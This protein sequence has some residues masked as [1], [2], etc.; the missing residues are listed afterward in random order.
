MHHHVHPFR[1]DRAHATVATVD[2]TDD[3]AVRRWAASGLMHLT[4]PVTSSGWGPPAGL[5]PLL[6][7]FAA[8]IAAASERL[9]ARVEIDPLAVLADRAAFGGT[10]RHGR[11]SC[12]GG[13]RLLRAADGWIALTLARDDDLDLLPAWSEGALAADLVGGEHPWS[14]VADWCAGQSAVRLVERGMLLGLAVARLG[15]HTAPQGVVVERLGDAEPRPLAETTVVDLS[16]LWSG[17][18]CGMLLRT[19]GCRVVKVESPRRPDG[20]R[21]G[22]RQFFDHLHAGSASVALD[23][24]TPSGRD[25]LVDLLRRS[26]VVIEGSRPRALRHLGIDPHELLATGPRVWVSIT[27]HGYHGPCA[28]RVGFGDD[29]AVA[30]GLVVGPPGDPCFCADAVA[31]PLTGLASAA[32]VFEALA[33][34]GRWHLD[35]ALA[36]VA[37]MAVGPT[38]P[39]PIGVRAQRPRR[40]VVTWCARPLGADTERLLGASAR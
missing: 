28:D 16:S 7:S 6:D 12:G 20:T 22:D 9:G 2:L 33:D 10:T 31:D 15:E 34:G 36:A 14:H 29:A 32:A 25:Q 40:P 13:T 26:D 35:A 21:R 5:V 19:A 30:A 38:L 23:V 24:A 1:V 3:S 18:L 37:S 39:V 17:P 11:T 4:G 27:G 8:R